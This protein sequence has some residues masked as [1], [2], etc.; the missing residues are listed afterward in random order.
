ML[1]LIISTTELAL[2][3]SLKLTRM[4]IDISVIFSFGL[5]LIGRVQDIISLG[6]LGV[7]V[8]ILIGAHGEFKFYIGRVNG[9]TPL[10]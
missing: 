8:F 7:Q 3:G 5:G 1:W 2:V 9:K 4:D 6:S 10:F